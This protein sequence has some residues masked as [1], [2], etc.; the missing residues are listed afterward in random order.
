MY[1]NENLHVGSAVPKD[2]DKGGY[3]MMINFHMSPKNIYCEYALESPWRGDSNE[4]S[5][6]MFSWR[7]EK[8]A[9]NY[10]QIPT[11]SVSLVSLCQSSTSKDPYQCHD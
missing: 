4:Y 11:S 8:V 1:K 6:G 2:T 7:T 5:Q 9:F 10:L 3:W